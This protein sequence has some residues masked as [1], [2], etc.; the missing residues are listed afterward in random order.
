MCVRRERNSNISRPDHLYWYF[1]D[2]ERFFPV[3]AFAHFSD[4][5]L[6]PFPK[7]Q[8][9]QLVNKRALSYL[10]FLKKRGRLHRAE[11]LDKALVAMRHYA[12]QH[13]C[14]TGDLVNLALPSEIELAAAWLRDLGPELTCTVVPGNH[15]VLVPSA[16]PR[17]REAWAPWI[18]SANNSDGFPSLFQKGDV[19]FIGLSSAVATPPC[20]ASGRLDHR[21]LDRL[22]EILAATA[23]EGYFR[24]ISIH[25]PPCL[26]SDSWRRRLRDGAALCEVLR[27]HGAE[28][29][30]HGHKE[31]SMRDELPGSLRGIP[32][33]G[34]GSASMTDEGN[35]NSGHFHGFRLQKTASGFT[36]QA[37]HFRYRSE[38]AAFTI[39]ST[40]HLEYP[41]QFPRTR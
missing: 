33:F 27:A 16:L 5:H 25:H 22:E 20:F 2:S 10:S 28:L 31:K 30:L 13:L 37:D 18:E 41:I 29:I 3:F 36:L 17:I 6:A 39:E 26:Q 24:V 7:P 4:L 12:P 38:T 15:D 8:L 11:V 19:A 9:A 14:V 21:Q 32:V 35:G 34:A 1:R 23:A 40:E